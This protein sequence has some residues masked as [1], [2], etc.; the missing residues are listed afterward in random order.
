MTEQDFDRF[1]ASLQ[2]MLKTN[3]RRRDAIVGELRDHLLE[4]LDELVAQGV[5]RD[6]AMTRALEEFGDAAVLAAHFTAISRNRNR[7]ILMRT[8]VGT[9]AALAAVLVGVVAFWP[10]DAS[11]PLAPRKVT[12]QDEPKE[13]KPPAAEG[14]ALLDED[15]LDD[16]TVE[17][18]K[19]PIDV[20]LIETPLSDALSFTVG[21]A[22]VQFYLDQRA[23]DDIGLTADAPVSLSLRSISGE[24]ALDLILK[25]L[26]LTYVLRSGIVMVT[27]PEEAEYQMTVRVYKLKDLRTEMEIAKQSDTQHAVEALATLAEESQPRG[28]G[29]GFGPARPVE[30]DTLRVPLLE[31]M[32]QLLERRDALEATNPEAAK[33]VEKE[34]YQLARTVLPPPAARSP[35]QE[36]VELI[37][38]SINPDSWDEV[39]GPGSIGVF[40]D[41]LVV[42]NSREV[43]RKIDDLLR[44]LRESGE[45]PAATATDE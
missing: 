32:L 38:T 34:F 28:F 2:G 33:K 15:A 23:L 30:D 24:M 43:H 14:V 37:M 6:E 18:L 9:V 12:A 36:V 10:Q 16:A 5:S 19:K 29:G 31:S 21:A 26:D 42:T 8:T 45:A 22:E 20:D 4:R 40:R 35:Y 13:V 39:G 1:L 41:K 27:T 17:K 7:R 3:R 44:Q 11:V 25:Q